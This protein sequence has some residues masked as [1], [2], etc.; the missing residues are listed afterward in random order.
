MTNQIN[1]NPYPIIS[2]ER[3]ILKSPK[4][5]DAPQFFKLQSDR[6]N[7]QYMDAPIADTIEF[8]EKFIHMI[9]GGIRRNEWLYWVIQLKSTEEMIGTI[10]LWNFSE[11]K[12]TAEVGY[13]LNS[14]FQRKGFMSEALET[15]L[16][17]AFQN[18]NLRMIEA[19]THIDNKAS[20]G[21]LKKYNFSFSKLIKQAHADERK[22]FELALYQLENTRNNESNN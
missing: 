16:A 19:Y 14:T 9:Q 20:I 10:C 8:S 1:L 12:F 3:L 4:R 7:R 21:L 15:T 13:E 18:L 5:E 22:S 2:T 6:I 11:D 17:F